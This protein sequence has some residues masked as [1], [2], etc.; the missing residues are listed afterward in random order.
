MNKSHFLHRVTEVTS[1]QRIENELERI[2][3]IKIPI[4]FYTLIN[5]TIV[6]VS[7]VSTH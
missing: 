1:T 5:L 3:P 2:E 4:L 6:L 7:T